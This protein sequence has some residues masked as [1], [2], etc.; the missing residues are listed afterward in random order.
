MVVG[1][2]SGSSEMAREDVVSEGQD[3]FKTD[4]KV[5]RPKVYGREAQG[6]ERIA[7]TDDPRF[8]SNSL[9]QLPIYLAI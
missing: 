7:K 2:M 5:L 3:S 1:S 8:T 4:T 6:A 9:I